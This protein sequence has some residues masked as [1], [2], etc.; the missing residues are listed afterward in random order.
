MTLQTT[1]VR[2]RLYQDGIEIN[3]F[4]PDLV[5]EDS[6][7]NPWAVIYVSANAG[8]EVLAIGQLGTTVKLLHLKVSPSDV[9]KITV[10]LNGGASFD[11]SPRQIFSDGTISSLTA[12]NSSSSEVPV[13]WKAVYQ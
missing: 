4:I 10:K 7:S 13:Y 9:N 8:N 11:L 1:E 5:F 3:P 12:S 6:V 2:Y